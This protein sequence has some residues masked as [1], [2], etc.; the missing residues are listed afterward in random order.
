MK[1][2]SCGHDNA[3]E[4]KFC[5]RCGTAMATAAPVAPA[6]PAAAPVSPPAVPAPKGSPRRTAKIIVLGAL[7][8]VLGGGGYVGYKIFNGGG[9]SMM[10]IPSMESPKLP[11]M[12]VE[13]QKD[14]A[15]VPQETSP[16]QGA[17]STAEPPKDAEPAPAEPP[18]AVEPAPAP[19]PEPVPPK[20]EPPKASPPKAPAPAPKAAPK[21]SPKAPPKAAPSQAAPAEPPRPDRWALMAQEMENCKRQ[22]FL[23]RVV[24]EQKVGQKYCA[25][26]WGTVPQCGGKSQ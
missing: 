10:P 12:Q 21:A 26:Y 8:L 13:P 4:A 18:K 17:P 2:I 11:P 20:A 25:G 16:A 19:A 9:S 23:D 7:A 5:G 1:C 24:C 14:A 6:A 22:S 15:P 3:P